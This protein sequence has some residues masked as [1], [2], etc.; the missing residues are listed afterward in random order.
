M[1]LCV[2]CGGAITEEPQGYSLK[3][4]KYKDCQ[5]EP[6]FL[7]KGMNGGMLG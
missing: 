2:R 4:Y 7:K 6:V 5:Y 1:N 3:K